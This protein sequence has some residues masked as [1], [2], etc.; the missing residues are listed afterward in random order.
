VTTTNVKRDRWVVRDDLGLLH[1]ALV[2]RFFNS[3]N[4][5]VTVQVSTAC[6]PK[7][8]QMEGLR[9]NYWHGSSLPSIV[10]HGLG[11]PFQVIEY[12]VREV[13]TCLM[14]LGA[15]SIE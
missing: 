6:C 13:P 12:H 8:M 2:A 11:R 7:V 14:C 9:G 15:G 10:L 1:N 5:I 4:E 3:D